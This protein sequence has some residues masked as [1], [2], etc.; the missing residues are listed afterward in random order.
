MGGM[1]DPAIG[2]WLGRISLACAAYPKRTVVAIVLMTTVVGMGMTQLETDSDLLK[3]LPEDNPHTLAAQRAATEFEGFY[4]FVT[5]FYAIDEDKCE[6]VT[7][8]QLPY[9]YLT[10]D[11]D[12][13]EITCDTVMHEAYI[14]GMDEIWHFIREEIP[15]A[16]Y[17]IDFAQL[18]KVINWTNDGYFGDRPDQSIL[19]PLINNEPDRVGRPPDDRAF[20][21][22]DTSPQGALTFYYSYMGVL[23]ADEAAKDTVANT[24]KAG[25]TL[26]F[27]NTSDGTSRVELGAAVYD[28]VDSYQAAINACDDTDPETVCTLKWNVFSGDGL[29]V[30]GVSAVDA[31]ASEVTQRDI[32]VLAPIIIWA[33]ITILYVAFRDVRVI[34]VA[35]ANLL[36]AFVWTAGMMGWLRIPFS[37]L[38]MTVVPLILGVGIDYGI[39]MVSEY[40][41]HK[42]D[43]MGNR[44]AFKQAGKRAGIAMAIATVTTI[45]GL[46]MMVLSPSVLMGQLGI[47]SSI[48]LLVTF[49]FTLT[50]IPAVLTL[51]A[52]DR[53]AARPH[54]GSSWVP[55][56][57]SGVARVRWLAAIVVIGLSVAAWTNLANLEN[58]AFGDPDKNYP[59][60][61]RVRDD[62]EWI[63]DEFFGGRSDTQTNYLI[64]EGDFTRPEMHA[65]LDGLVDRFA[66]DEEIQG[67]SVTALP[68]I[69]RGYLAV[70]Q[71][72][73]DAVLNQFILSEGPSEVA[74]VEYPKSREEMKAVLDDMFASPMANFATILV[75]E[76]YTMGL[77]TY[78]TQNRLENFDEAQRVWIQ[79]DEAIR[80]TKAALGVGE[81]IQV[82]MFGNNAFSY[83]FITE[84]QPW[85]NTI[86]YVSFGTV[87]VLIA[88]LTRNVRATAC[89]AAIMGVT[90]L[91]WLGTLPLMGIGL[92]V[93]LMLPLV[94]I[95]A[96]GSDDAIHLIWNMELSEDRRKVYRFV[97]QAVLLT[98]V[99]TFI[100]FS[101]FSRQTDLL[102]TRTLL[103]TAMAVLVM[104]LATMLIVPIFYPP[105][106]REKRLPASSR[107][108]RPTGELAGEPAG[109]TGRKPT[110][111][112]RVRPR[113]R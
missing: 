48:A 75:N 27:F 100:A 110:I 12:G 112:A 37:A 102:V 23:A 44:D 84:Q 26:I 42:A 67:G 34:M 8:Q 4:D 54:K 73:P 78:D 1:R 108:A 66:T 53:I 63:S 82:H 14:R 109:K 92:S 90:S 105:E 96:I 106:R 41:E 5:F 95:M 43:K 113:N 77:M 7:Q 107:P 72:T 17:A 65:F 71:G 25:R 55:K 103:A 11:Q 101:I 29:A 51:T 10:Y 52:K 88:A 70:N 80:E 87:I 93:G 22:P 62:S 30:R 21:M 20:S 99:T 111:L 57:A 28:A 56:L 79:S 40:L 47:V 64:V 13:S 81:E 15:Q 98:S 83:L 18:I 49:L 3:I 35:A 32:S 68:R 76:D 2:R 33:I 86:G 50:L 104:W 6:R 69:V 31:H 61:D 59:I 91:W 85:V 38:N 94:F 19:E 97:G 24:L 74:D 89:T 45:A 39:H 60:G 9:R 36:I 46:M 58:E 16:E